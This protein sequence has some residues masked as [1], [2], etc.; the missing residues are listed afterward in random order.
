MSKNQIIIAL[1]VLCLVGT[2]WGSVQDKKSTSL[3]RQL[4]AMRAQPAATETVAADDSAVKQVQAELEDIKA[5]N[6]AL[7]EKAATLKGTISSQKDEIASL[8]EQSANS[9]G[10]SVDTSALEA[11]IEESTA[12]LAAVE[13]KLAAATA[14]CENKDAELAAAKD[15]CAKKNAEV[16]AAKEAQAAAEKTQAGLEEMKTSLA[17]SVDAYNAKSQAL[18]SKVEEAAHRIL[19]LE[20]AL[21]ERT[22]LLQ[23]KDVELAR[24]TLNMNVLLS[25]I[26]AQNNSLAILEETRVAMTKE[27]AAKFL[28]IQELEAKLS[29]QVS[30]ADAPAVQHH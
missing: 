7:L 20:N 26:A 15:L 19:S 4:E 27:L 16:A 8:K 29:E 18:S 23:A 9:G 12:A 5:Q 25:K 11:K 14:L 10:G 21:E 1:V 2:I 22:K 24:T 30:P 28:I 17:N 3:E 13:E 6:A